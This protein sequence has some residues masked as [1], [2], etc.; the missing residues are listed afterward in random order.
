MVAVRIRPLAPTE[1]AAAQEIERAAGEPFR[2]IGMPE[3]ADDDPLPADVLLEFVHAGR[4][5]AADLDG[6]PVAY[7]IALPVDGNLHI[8][9]VSVHPAAAHRGI[10]RALIDHLAAVSAVPALTLTTFTEVRWN[11]PY[12]VRCGFRILAEAELTPGLRAIRDAEIALGRY[13]WPRATMRRDI[14]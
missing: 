9:Q 7:L 10:G 5:W 13:R 14:A 2:A 3:I 4:A 11:A 12:Y 6:D 1:V 8:E